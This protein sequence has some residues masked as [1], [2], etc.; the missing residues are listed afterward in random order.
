[1]L[2]PAEFERAEKAAD[3]SYCSLKK[4]SRTGR[5]SHVLKYQDG[6]VI[7]HLTV[8]STCDILKS[9]V[10]LKFTASLKKS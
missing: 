3:I 10:R 9:I 7:T 4:T 5:V 1:M 2:A 8:S 6:S